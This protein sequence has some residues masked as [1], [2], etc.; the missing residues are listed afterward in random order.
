MY[1]QYKCVFKRV[2]KISLSKYPIHTS[3]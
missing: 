1:I 3:E 2:V